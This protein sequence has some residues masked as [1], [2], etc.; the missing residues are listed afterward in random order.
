M[1]DLTPEERARL[2]DVLSRLQVQTKI[3]LEFTRAGR[4]V[5]TL[6]YCRSCCRPAV[7]RIGDF[8]ITDTKNHEG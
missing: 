5:S 1:S 2:L 7:F 8:L 4:L 6:R 3:A